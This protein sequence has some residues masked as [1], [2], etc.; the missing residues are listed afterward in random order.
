MHT[1]PRDFV[2]VDM[3]GLK[4]ALQTR[5]R[6]SGRSVS[7]L[8]RTAVAGWLGAAHLAPSDTIPDASDGHATLKVSIRLHRTDV[9]LLAARAKDAGVS[10]G[11][12]IRGLLT[13]V[14][15]MTQSM[16]RPADVLS[17]LVC[18]NAQVAALGKHVS[19]LCLLLEHGDGLAAR[20]YRMQLTGLVDELRQH[21]RLTTEALELL[22]GRRGGAPTRTR[23]P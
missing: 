22:R 11:A 21:L 6:E 16:A 5:S 15:A 23:S 9:E 18:S 20:Q 17:A 8:V 12:L 10:R 14:P 4:A 2:S 1:P 7:D 13:E 3:R 19:R